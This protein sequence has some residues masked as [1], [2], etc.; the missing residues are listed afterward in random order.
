MVVGTW[1][2]S[3]NI[4]IMNAETL[5]KRQIETSVKDV[6]NKLQKQDKHFF[7]SDLLD[8]Y[9]NNT[10]IVTDVEDERMVDHPQKSYHQLRAIYPFIGYSA[11]PCFP[12]SVLQA[13]KVKYGK[14]SKKIC[15]WTDPNPHSESMLDL[16]TFNPESITTN[17][18]DKSFVDQLQLIFKDQENYYNERLEIQQVDWIKALSNT[19]QTDSQKTDYGLFA[20]KNIKKGTIFLYS[21][22]IISSSCA[23]I[24]STYNV[25]K[26]ELNEYSW[27]CLPSF[28]ILSLLDIQQA[29]RILL[30]TLYLYDRFD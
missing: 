7:I 24:Y 9:I 15:K 1:A 27:D 14:R 19:P 25:E 18:K 22:L 16:Y 2:N 13:L 17:I 23:N 5:I 6:I 20:K 12:A 26:Y 11:A 8:G 29:N 3:P 4:V 30:H 28:C 10:F 21:G